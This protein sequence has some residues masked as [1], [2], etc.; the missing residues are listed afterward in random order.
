MKPSSKRNKSSFSEDQLWKPSAPVC[1]VWGA[2]VRGCE[3]TE[4]SGGEG[5][6]RVGPAV[7]KEGHVIIQ[8]RLH[9]TEDETEARRLVWLQ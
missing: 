2:G 4:D 6:G 7:V 3:H 8:D 1:P 5:R 9:F